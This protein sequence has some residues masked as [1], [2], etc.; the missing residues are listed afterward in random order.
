MF[1]G[2]APKGYSA[3]LVVGGYTVVY[4]LVAKDYLVAREAKSTWC[5]V[6]CNPK[7]YSATEAAHRSKFNVAHW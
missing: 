4:T 6:L 5:V 7:D 2:V 1:R 3:V